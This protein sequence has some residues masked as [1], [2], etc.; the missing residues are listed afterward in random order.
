MRRFLLFILTLICICTP[1]FSQARDTRRYVSVETV[2]VKESA[3][4]FAGEIGKLSLGDEVTMIRE[5]GKWTEIQMGSKS[6]WVPT[7][8]LSTR[9]II[10]SGA[11]IS[12]TELALAGKGFSRA[13]EVEYRKN[14]LDYSQVDSMEGVSIP[15]DE[16]LHF[17]TEGRLA[18]GDN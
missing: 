8:S 7:A 17:I 13:M 5:S 11:T 3:G 2:V 9:R 12:A 16:L 6:G 4:F 14:G 1:V 18:R 15:P 10:A